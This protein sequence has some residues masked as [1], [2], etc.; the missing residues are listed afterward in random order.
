MSIHSVQDD[1][2]VTL[3][4]ARAAAR[5]VEMKHPN[6][7]TMSFRMAWGPRSRTMKDLDTGEW[8]LGCTR[9]MDST[10]GSV[11]IRVKWEGRSKAER[12]TIV[13]RL[14]IVFSR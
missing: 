11:N 14:L 13:R 1:D 7:G 2:G 3:Y 5:Y 4:E 8:G 6:R 9:V 10:W 12:Y